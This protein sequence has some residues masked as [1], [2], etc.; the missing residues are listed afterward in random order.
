MQRSKLCLCAMIILVLS[1]PGFGKDYRP[2]KEVKVL[3]LFFVPKG[4]PSPTARQ[5]TDLQKHVA[6]TQ[7]RYK[8]MLKGRDTF[9]L[10]K[11]KPQVYR[12]EHDL[13]YYR[14]QEQG[15]A[16]QMVDSSR[17]PS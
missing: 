7:A 4:E 10:A 11:G 15:A 2:P 17:P 16:P 14:A 5:L 9:M 12:A 13:A 1:S 6:W 8:Q 3:P